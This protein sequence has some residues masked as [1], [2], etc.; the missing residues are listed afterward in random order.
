MGIV[1]ENRVII[2]AVR[3]NVAQIEGGKQGWMNKN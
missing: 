1:V 3:E 2:L